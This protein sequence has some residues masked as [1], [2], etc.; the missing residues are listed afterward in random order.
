MA[1]LRLL[2]GCSQGGDPLPAP[3]SPWPRAVVRMPRRLF[4]KRERESES[5]VG[6]GRSRGP[7][8]EARGGERRK[9]GRGWEDS[10]PCSECEW[11]AGP[12]EQEMPRAKTLGEKLLSQ[13]SWPAPW[14]PPA[15]VLGADPSLHSPKS[16]LHS[17]PHAV[18]TRSSFHYGLQGGMRSSGCVRKAPP[19]PAPV[20]ESPQPDPVTSAEAQALFLE[21]KEQEPFCLNTPARSPPP[22]FCRHPLLCIVLFVLRECERRGKDSV[23]R[24]C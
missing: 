24:F 17:P 5:G 10:R 18:Q 2:S 20:P 4:P 16:L 23:C 7:S 6:G 15:I 19:M 12:R 3:R 9:E 21:Q 14:T 22:A 11:T 1:S 13:Q 8:V